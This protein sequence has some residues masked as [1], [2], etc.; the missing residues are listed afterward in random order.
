MALLQEFG[1]RLNG[2]DFQ[3]YLFLLTREQVSPAFDFVPYK[4]GGFSFQSYADKRTMTGYGMIKNMDNWSISDKTDY[5]SQLTQDDQ[6][7]V[8]K[9]KRE[10][11]SLNGKSLVRYVYLKYPYYAIKSEIAVDCLSKDELAEVNKHKPTQNGYAFFTIG[12]EGKTFD[13]YLNQLVENNIRVLC[14]VR[15][16]PISMK[17]GFSRNQLEDAC[18]KLGIGYIHFPE[19]GIESAKRKN[20]ADK[21]DYEKLFKEYEKKTLPANKVS[22]EILYQVFLKDKRIAITCFEADHNFCHRHK[23]VKQIKKQPNWA[24]QIEH[25]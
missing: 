21:T 7:S 19:L 2:T 11:G 4:F 10:C 14:D 8:M 18:K 15:K 12:Y 22:L 17:Y 5:I 3:K 1:G 24:F 13:Y 6:V 9:V 23:I 16:N 25:L 20:L